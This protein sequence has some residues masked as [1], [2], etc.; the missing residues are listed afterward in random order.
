VK[1]VN[2]G[3]KRVWPNGPSSVIV[4]KQTVTLSPTNM[5][6][7]LTI[8]ITINNELANYYFEERPWDPIDRYV[9]HETYKSRF[10]GYSYL[11]KAT[12]NGEITVS[13]VFTVAEQS[14]FDRAVEVATKGKAIVSEAIRLSRAG[15]KLVMVAGKYGK[16]VNGAMFFISGFFLVTDLHDWLFAPTPDTGNDGN[17][18]VGG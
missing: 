14:E 4:N 13:D 5:R 12:F 8:T 6:E 18:V 17:N 11:V 2:S 10:A 16:I 7:D 3:G 15:K 1:E 9:F